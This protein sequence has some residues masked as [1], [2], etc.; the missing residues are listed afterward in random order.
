M[1]NF[2]EF[3]LYYRSPSGGGWQVG[4]L[5]GESLAKGLTRPMQRSRARTKSPGRLTVLHSLWD[6]DPLLLA[7]VCSPRMLDEKTHLPSTRRPVTRQPM[8]DSS[9]VFVVCCSSSR[10]RLNE[11]TPDKHEEMIHCS[12]ALIPVGLVERIRR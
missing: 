10:A 6:D 12:P 11:E 4:R 9:P 8:K 2:R 7:V 3:A 5:A 1:V